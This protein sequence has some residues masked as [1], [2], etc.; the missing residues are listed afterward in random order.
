MLGEGLYENIVP[1][2]M[3]HERLSPQA[4]MNRADILMHES[5]ARCY[6]AEAALMTE[7]DADAKD[8]KGKNKKRARDV[9]ER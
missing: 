3:Y 7:I 2:L 6:A 5:Y 9:V 1:L 4:V 8:E